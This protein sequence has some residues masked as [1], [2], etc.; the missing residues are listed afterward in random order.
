MTIGRGLAQVASAI[1][2]DKLLSRAGNARCQANAEGRNRAL[3]LPVR[4][5]GH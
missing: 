3:A 1:D 5:N 4:N 2:E